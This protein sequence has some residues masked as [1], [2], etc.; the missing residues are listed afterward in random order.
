MSPELIT[1][2]ALLV[3]ALLGGGGIAVLRKRPEQSVDASLGVGATSL[4]EIA[5]ALDREADRADALERRILLCPQHP[6]CPVR[7]QLR[8]E[9][10]L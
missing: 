6:T 1:A 7:E 3:T 4:R 9:D 2:I 10:T 5:G 8:T